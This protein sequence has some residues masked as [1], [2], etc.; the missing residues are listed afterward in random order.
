MRQFV[1]LACFILSLTQGVFSAAC[2]DNTGTCI[3]TDKYTCNGT[4]YT[5]ACAG[6]REIKCCV[7]YAPQN[8]CATPN[9]GQGR[10]LRSSN[11]SCSGTAWPT[12][13]CGGNKCCIDIPGTLGVDISQLASVDF[14][15]CLKSSGFEFV[16]VRASCST[17]TLDTHAAQSMKNALSAGFSPSQIDVY[18][19]P[20]SRQNAGNQMRKMVEHLKEEGLSYSKLERK[21]MK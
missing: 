3:D 16:I 19:F 12:D 20:D 2:R 7:P 15:S 14:F 9:V 6:A 13:D 21:R 17:G 10:C 18:I 1:F 5:D 11:S 4:L 8:N